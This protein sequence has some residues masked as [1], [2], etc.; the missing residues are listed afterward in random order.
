MQNEMRDRL[1]TLHQ[2]ATKIFMDKLNNG[3]VEE[4]QFIEFITDYQ[5]ANGVFALPFNVGDKA[6]SVECGSGSPM[7][8]EDIHIL[9][10]DVIFEWAQYD[11]SYEYTETWDE[12]DFSID[13][14]GKTIFSSVEELPTPLL[15]S[16]EQ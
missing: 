13:E 3:E 6:Y 5:I 15:E 11:R 8:I 12:G 10:D 4:K 9:K 2:E 14:V 16:E 7:E 1:I